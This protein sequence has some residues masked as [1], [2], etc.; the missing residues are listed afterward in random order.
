MVFSARPEKHFYF[1]ER[2]ADRLMA[3]LRDWME[4]GT[5][6]ISDCR[7]TYR[8]LEKHVYSHTTHT[9]QTVNHTIGFVDVLSDAHTNP[10]QSTWQH[11]KAFLNPC[12]R[13]GTTSVTWPITCFRRGANPWIWN[14]SQSS[15]Q[16]FHA[17]PGAP[18]LHSIPVISPSDLPSPNH[19]CKSPPATGKVSDIT[20]YMATNPL[21]SIQVKLRYVRLS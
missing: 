13:M 20:Y 3:V 2:N 12:N 5:T 1:P 7:S 18:L 21:G 10:F 16:S 9:H 6:V 4:P 19:W 17:W 11:V 15:S 8:D 14:S